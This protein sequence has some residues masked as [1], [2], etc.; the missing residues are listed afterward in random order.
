MMLVLA[1]L[2]VGCGAVSDYET[3]LDVYNEQPIPA[4]RD[5]SVLLPGGETV[6]TMESGVHDSLWMGDD[7]TA[8]V[9]TLSSGDLEQTICT[10]TG[11]KTEDLTLIHRQQDEL[12]RYECVWVSAGEGGDQLNRAVILD[13]GSYCYVLSLHAAAE[14]TGDLSPVWE[15]VV[16]SVSLSIVP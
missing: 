10:V 6:V 14:K 3:V 4:P 13:D 2:L 7:F 12:H 15:N 5:L 16:D 9:Q 8:C 1:F 11:L